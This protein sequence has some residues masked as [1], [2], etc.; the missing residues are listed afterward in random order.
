MSKSLSCKQTEQLISIASNVQATIGA[1]VIGESDEGIAFIKLM[2]IC[3]DYAVVGG[4][5]ARFGAY[6]NEELL[7]KRLDE[8]NIRFYK[9]I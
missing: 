7:K 9:R 2:R 6:R 5:G 1:P 8:F 3:R 4:N